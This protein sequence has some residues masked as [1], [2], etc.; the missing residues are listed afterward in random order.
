MLNFRDTTEQCELLDLWC[1]GRWNVGFS[2]WQFRYRIGVHNRQREGLVPDLIFFVIR[3]TDLRTDKVIHRSSVPELKNPCS[4]LGLSLNAKLLLIS[5][6]IWMKLWILNLITILNKSY[7]TKI[8]KSQNLKILKSIN[9]YIY[10]S[11]NLKI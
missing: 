8:S 2:Y 5:Q 11:I 6:P 4:K 10:K 9:L 7:D 1:I 3:R